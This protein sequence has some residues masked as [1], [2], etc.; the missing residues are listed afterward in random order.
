M[1]IICLTPIVSC[2]SSIVKDCELGIADCEFRI[3]DWGLKIL[4]T[5]NL[6]GIELLRN[7]NYE[8]RIRSYYETKYHP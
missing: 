1:S 7:T 3:E 8:L 5:R 6:R 2:H 4:T